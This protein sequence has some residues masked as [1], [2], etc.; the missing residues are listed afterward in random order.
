[1]MNVQKFEHDKVSLIPTLHQPLINKK[2]SPQISKWAMKLIF[3]LT[4]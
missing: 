4:L 1:M 3:N 2:N